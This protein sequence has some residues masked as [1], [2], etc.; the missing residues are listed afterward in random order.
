MTK[1]Q[2]FFLNPQK[3]NN[4]QIKRL[5]FQNNLRSKYLTFFFVICS[6]LFSFYDVFILKKLVSAE[7][8]LY[9]FKADIV[10]LVFSFVFALYIFFNQV[11]TYE[12]IHFHHKY[13]H[14]IISLFILLWSTFKSVIFIKYGEGDFNIAIICILLTSIIYIFPPIVYLTQ[15]LF[16][17]VFAIFSLLMYHFTISEISKRI[18][19]LIPILLIS[20]LISHYIYNLQIKILTNESG[21]IRFSRKK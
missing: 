19:L 6:L 14:G 3:L 11:K 2:I 15:L 13:V 4:S 18:I 21:I 10:F 17:F 9:H 20:L 8:F 5:C 12:H 16:T 1:S 7:E